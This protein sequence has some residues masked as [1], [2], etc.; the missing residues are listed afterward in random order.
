[1]LEVYAEENRTIWSQELNLTGAEKLELRAF[2][3][4]N[5]LPQNRAY[6]YDYFR[7]NCSTRVRDALD[8]V[9]DGALRA[10]LS[11]ELTDR[12]YRSESLRL[13][14]G[15]VPLHAGMD[16]GLG[17][18]ADH[19]LTAWDESF[20]PMRLRDHVRGI[21]VAGPDGPVPL[22]VN[23]RILYQSTLDAPPDVAPSRLTEF[24]AFG[25][26]GFLLVW[27][28]SR[29]VPDSG[30]ATIAV[31]ALVFV[32]ALLTG[33]LG[34]VLAGLWI[35][36]DHAAAFRNANLLQANP[37]A[38]VFAVVGPMAILGD[39]ARNLALALAILLAGLSAFELVLHF[40]PGIDQTT[41]RIIALFL[42]IHLGVLL[43]V[44]RAV[45]PPATSRK[46]RTERAWRAREAR[47]SGRHR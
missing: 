28:L 42:P 13:T 47:A 7:D 8:A 31:A 2:L 44:L 11:T 34:V 37:L 15:N 18:F 29:F 35:F 45:R 21:T 36:T 25:L 17:P 38:L 19:F 46:I 16:L 23:E 14:S 22:V 3:E 32:W 20:I 1:M 10:K 27:G 41:G 39:R 33:V 12:T 26:L 5:A 24:L 40:V 6:R 4:R 9:L 30:A 43:A